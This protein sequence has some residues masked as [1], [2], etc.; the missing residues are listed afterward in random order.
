MGPI[1]RSSDWL[2]ATAVPHRVRSRV[3][4]D[5]DKAIERHEKSPSPAN[6]T[7]IRIAL[8]AWIDTKGPGWEAN[9]RNR[10][11]AIS[12]L[13][14]TVTQLRVELP[15][16]ERAALQFQI[17]AQKSLLY[18]NFSGAHLVLRGFRPE[19]EVQN[20][21]QNLYGEM[22]RIDPTR[23]PDGGR[24]AAPGASSVQVAQLDRGVIAVKGVQNSVGRARR[25]A[26][27][28]PKEMADEGLQTILSQLFGGP[29]T[30]A[31]DVALYVAQELGGGALVTTAQQVAEM[32]PV[33]SLVAG[34]V[35]ALGQWSVAIYDLYQ[36]IDVANQAWVLHP[37]AASAALGGMQRLL[38]RETNFA[39]GKATITSAGFAANVA[40]HAAKGAGSVA[41]PV[42]GATVAAAQAAR[43][44]ALFAMQVREAVLM[45]KALK[46]P[47]KMNFKVFRKCPLL[48]CY[49]LV[50]ASDSELLAILW[51]EF[52]QAGYME[53]MV[54]LVEPL[55]S[56]QETAAGLIA[57]SPFEI[58]GVPTRMKTSHSRKRKTANFLLGWVS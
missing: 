6:V 48:G 44:V 39:A 5:L 51:D 3:L 41:A 54:K 25:E 14:E 30:S 13:F 23:V 27:A 1:P 31:Q 43:V 36:E 45:H 35:K 10:T 58:A 11:R 56:L 46:N 22:R 21:R 16:E 4:G 8:R 19:V 26:A 2:A 47:A 42:V 49:M 28:A 17:D 12:Q 15:P 32:L 53:E 9:E 37:G 55:K 40:L 33:V 20:A 52:G 34:G 18:R 38:R 24:L 7:R 29:I 50:G 57:S